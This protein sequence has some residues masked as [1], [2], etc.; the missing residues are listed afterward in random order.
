MKK[1]L[2]LLCCLTLSGAIQAGNTLRQ[3]TTSGIIPRPARMAVDDE[4]FTLHVTT[5]IVLAD[6]M[7]GM[8]CAADLL[9]HSF[10]PVFGAELPVVRTLPNKRPGIEMLL[11]P[12]LKPEA[13]TLSITSRGI[14]ITAGSPAGIFYGCQ[15]LLQLTPPDM[16]A[17]KGISAVQIPCVRIEDA[18][19]F[20]IRGM[21]LDVSRHFFSVS[22]IKELLDLLAMHKINTFHWHLTDDQ[23]SLIHISEP[24]RP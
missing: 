1:I 11:S 2:I 21:M 5:P 16:A 22:Q 7:F 13:Y 4:C 20:G 19:A 14:R 3:T 17:A 23:L 12:A 8:Q 24:T 15:S 6:T 9:N 18:P 10:G